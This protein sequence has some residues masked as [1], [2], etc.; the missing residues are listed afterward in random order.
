[1]SMR[2]DHMAELIDN[3]GAPK[4]PV[5]YQKAKFNMMPAEEPAAPREEERKPSAIDLG[6]TAAH[7]REA[8]QFGAQYVPPTGEK[9][10][11]TEATYTNPKTGEITRGANHQEANHNAPQE[12]TDRESPSYGFATDKGR[13]VDRNEAYNIAQ[14]AGQLKEAIS[15][16]QKFNADRGV[17]HS[18]MVNYGGVKKGGIAFMPAAGES[19]PVPTQ[20]EL[21]AMKARLPKYRAVI[22]KAKDNEYDQRFDTIHIYAEGEKDAGYPIGVAKLYQ[23]DGDQ[24]PIVSTGVVRD[25]QGKGYGEALYREIAKYAQQNGYSYITSNKV[26]PQAQKVRTKLFEE[27]PYGYDAVTS[28]GERGV[29]SKV[30]SDISFMPASKLDEAHA[31]AVESGDTE[32]AQKL[33]DEAAKKAGYTIGPLWH[34]TSKD[35]YEFRPA[36]DEKAIFLSTDKNEAKAFAVGS[37]GKVMGPLYINAKTPEDLYHATDE[38]QAIRDARE[39]GF[40]GIKVTDQLPYSTYTMKPQ[41]QTA[42]YAVFDP[43]QIKSTELATYDD[44]GNLIPLSQRFDTSKQDIRFMPY[45][46]ELPKDEDGK[47][48]WAGFKAKTQ[49]IAKPLAGLSFMVS[50]KEDKS[51]M[52]MSA[53]NVLHSDS[54]VLPKPEKK[55]AN[56]K[57]AV[58][59]ADIATQHHGRV[60]TSNDI[61]PQEEQAFIKNGADEAEAALKSSGKNAGNWYSTAMKAA[62]AVAGVLHKVISDP[63]EAMKNPHFAKEPDPTKAAQFAFLIP[64]AIT[65]QNQTVPLNT[66][67]GEE[68]F[69]H[70]QKTGKFDPSKKYG[71]KAASISG[72]LELA[73][74]MID[75]MGGLTKLEDFIKQEFTVKELED[76]ASKIA[77]KKITVAGR[78]TDMVNGAAIFGPKIGQGFLQ[79]LMGKFD[80]VTIDLWMRRTW[81]RWTG[82]VVG[83]GVTGVRLGRLIQEY[84]NSGRKLPDNLKTLRTVMRSTGTT[85]TGK[86]TKPEMTISENVEDRIENDPEFRKSVEQL[87][88]DANAEFQGYYKLMGSPV[89]DAMMAEISKVAS[90]GKIKYSEETREQRDSAYNKLIKEQQKIKSALESKWDELS[91]E[92]KKALNTE[93]PTKAISKAKWIDQQHE[94]AGRTKVLSN[95]QKNAIK[96]QWAAA[97]KSIVADLN[98]IDIPTDQDRVVISRVVNGIRKEL[99]SRGYNVTN[100]DVQAILWYPE[101]D[102]WAKL[103]GEEES[104]LKQSYDD[105]LLKIAEQRGV[106]AEAR[107]VAKRIRGY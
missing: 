96:P 41:K 9:E 72:N 16:E 106:G 91:S 42:N 35:F 44:Q 66:R 104:N 81:G 74:H 31:K 68:Q 78:K 22:T 46:P 65:S 88:K 101:K 12:A 21:D 99:E 29:K 107:S 23:T 48:D 30:P 34:G 59:L 37:G 89:S 103:R 50:N 64:L 58:Q 80:P 61:T 28:R 24:L 32:E 19:K 100:A 17:L 73:N 7:S 15:E 47:V 60:I 4:V 105:E 76:A 102:L 57:V 8:K 63:K 90:V 20:E 25:F 82:D 51:P 52:P 84:R 14:S 93:D 1:M 13:I 43:N 54:D 92:Q 97:A 2:L 18:D 79:N 56:A 40:T 10:R 33:V 53:L 86:P 95:E 69:N 77:G 3:D 70:F 6:I 71:E 45:S 62:V 27:E 67:Y 49:E 5:S 36:G 39:N 83:D 75:V 87:S 98:P 55:V 38:R 11:I 26:S 94:K 85:K